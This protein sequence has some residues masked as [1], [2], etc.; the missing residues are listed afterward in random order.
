M[1]LTYNI[2]QFQIVDEAGIGWDN[3]RSTSSSKHIVWVQ[4]KNDLIMQHTYNIEQ[5]QIV[6]EPGIGWD[7]WR[8][9]SSSKHIV[10]VQGKNDLC[11]MCIP[12]ILSNSKS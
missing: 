9:T 7:N 12:T 10:W 5:L 2:E 8:S 11:N 4:G 3:W 6:E 1:L